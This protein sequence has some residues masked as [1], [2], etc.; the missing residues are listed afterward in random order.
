[1]AAANHQGPSLRNSSGSFATLAAILLASSF[2]RSFAA[3]LLPGSSSKWTYRVLYLQEK[4][5]D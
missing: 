2:V 1:M 5:W 3:D 4:R